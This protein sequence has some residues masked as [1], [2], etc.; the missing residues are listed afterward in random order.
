MNIVKPLCVRTTGLWM[1]QSESTT[2]RISTESPIQRTNTHMCDV[3]L[4]LFPVFHL[5]FTCRSQLRNAMCVYVNVAVSGYTQFVCLLFSFF[6]TLDSH[7]T[8]TRTHM[9]DHPYMRGSLVY[10]L[11]F[12]CLCVCVFELTLSNGTH[13]HVERMCGVDVLHTDHLCE[14]FDA[15]SCTALRMY[16]FLFI[17]IIC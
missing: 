13:T 6:F 5:A 16:V 12:K 8:N 17:F 4:S 14:P 11:H 1:K 2:D 7:H 10:R 15:F 9:H 3:V